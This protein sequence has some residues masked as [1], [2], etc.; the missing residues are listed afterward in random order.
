M[1]KW[2]ANKIATGYQVR[3]NVGKTT[4]TLKF[5]GNNT[6]AY[7]SRLAKGNYKFYIRSVLKKGSVNYYSAWSNPISITIK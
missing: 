1:L 3:Y 5:S 2:P 7:I 6:Y 4:K